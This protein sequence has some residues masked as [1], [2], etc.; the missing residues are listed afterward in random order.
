[1]AKLNWFH[2]N[3]NDIASQ[4]R[5]RISTVVLLINGTR[6]W[7]LSRHS[8]WTRYPQATAAAHRR[9]SQLFYDHGI[10]TLIQ[11]LFGFDLFDRGEDYLQFVL[12]HS[13][14]AMADED[15]ALWYRAARIRVSFYG[16]WREALASLGLPEIVEVLD[17]IAHSTRQHTDRNLL[18]GLFADRALDDIV[19]LAKGC[20]SGQDLVERYYGL[21]VPAIDFVVGSGQPALW[22]I[23]LLDFNQASLYFLKAPTFFITREVVRR[24]LHDHLFERLPDDNVGAFFP[25]SQKWNSEEVL[26]VGQRTPLGWVAQ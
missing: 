14:T 22:D 12:K 3:D 11:P 2:A 18:I 9:V 1:M 15:Y 24:I 23:P 17:D 26:G 10:S 5:P 25:Q 8:D 19:S 4:V 6:R 13:L 16:A 7:F 20:Q 21:S